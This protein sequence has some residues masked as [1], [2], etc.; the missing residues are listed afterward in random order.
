MLR[1]S[2]LASIFVLSAH[3]LALTGRPAMAAVRGGAARMAVTS[4]AI[5]IVVD[6]EIEPSRVDEFLKVIEADAIGSR[7]EP[8]CLYAPGG[9][10]HVS[11]YRQS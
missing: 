1:S 10:E 8:G 7:K 3:A 6:A 9:V 11:L 2:L 4:E 5:A